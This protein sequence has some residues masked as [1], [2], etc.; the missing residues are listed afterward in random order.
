MKNYLYG[1]FLQENLRFNPSECELKINL[2]YKNIVHFNDVRCFKSKALSPFL[3]FI[4]NCKLK[5]D[6]D[7]K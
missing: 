1:P 6:F 2:N 7:Y 3:I 4:K 5:T